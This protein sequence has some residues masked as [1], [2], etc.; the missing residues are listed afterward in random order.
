M[1]TPVL[2]NNEDDHTAIR[3]Q[4]K[5]EEVWTAFNNVMLEYI[6]TNEGRRMF[7]SIKA[8]IDNLQPSMT[9]DIYMDFIE[10]GRYAWTNN[11]WIKIY[12]TPSTT[13][14]RNDG[15]V[16]QLQRYRH[17]NSPNLGSFW[18]D[19]PVSFAR[20]KLTTRTENL[21][22]DQVTTRKIM[23]NPYAQHFLMTSN[24]YFQRQLPRIPG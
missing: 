3:V 15:H 18:M 19:N 9:Y 21:T 16:Q 7:P 2:S 14:V 13:N 11:Q 8:L 24:R 12:D 10:R 6:A 1:D 22:P 23:Y 5:D 20:L 4:M 17:E